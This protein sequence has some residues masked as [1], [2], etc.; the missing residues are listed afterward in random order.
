MS[1]ISSKVES[2]SKL[3]IEP[4]PLGRS[5]AIVKFCQIDNTIA[6]VDSEGTIFSNAVKKGYLYVAQHDPRIDRMVQCCAKMGLL[7]SEALKEFRE[8]RQRKIDIDKYEWAVSNLRLYADEL[9]IK[10]TAGQKAKLKL[11]DTTFKDETNVSTEQ[12]S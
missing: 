3:H 7:S 2:I 9:G 6:L 1:K 12:E 10:L 8:D 4:I 5:L 11:F